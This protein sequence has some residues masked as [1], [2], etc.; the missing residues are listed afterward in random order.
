MLYRSHV[1]ASILSREAAEFGAWW[2]GLEWSV[3]KI[4]SKP[5]RQ[6]DGPEARDIDLK[7]TGHAPVGNWTWHGSVPRTWEPTFIGSGTTKQV[8]L[9]I[10]NPI[11]GLIIYRATDTYRAGSYDPE[12]TTEDLCSGGPGIVF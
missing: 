12:T 4:L 1:S 8:I 10:F 7:P 2:H 11:G 6:A 5:A 3:Q 9:N